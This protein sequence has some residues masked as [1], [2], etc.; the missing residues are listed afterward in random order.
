MRHEFVWPEGIEKTPERQALLEAIKRGEQIIFLSG[1]AGSGKSKLLECVRANT[2][3]LNVA[4][5]APTGLAALNISGM[6]IHRSFKLPIGTLTDKIVRALRPPSMLAHIDLIV[7]DEVS[8]VRADVVAAMDVMLRRA[9]RINEPFGGTQMLFCGDL[10]QLAPVLT[11]EDRAAYIKILSIRGLF[12]HHAKVFDC[13]KPKVLE[14]TKIWRQKD[15]NFIRSLNN[16]RIGK[17][18]SSDLALLNSRR[19]NRPPETHV[20]LAPHNATVDH[21]NAALLSRLPGPQGNIGAEITGA[22]CNKSDRM[23]AD[24]PLSLKEGARVLM[25]NNDPDQRWCNGT[26]ATVLSWTE[27]A[28]KVELDNGERHEVLRARWSEGRYE[29]D[30]L[31]E[32]EAAQLVYVETGSFTQFPM[33]LGWAITIHKSQGMTL[34]RAYIDLGCGIFAHG[35]LYVALSRVVS[36]EGLALSRPIDPSDIIVEPNAMRLRGWGLLA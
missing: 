12:F 24:S 32:T 8:M 1:R 5:L 9:K 22:F 31:T 6:T 15:E 13:A 16:I 10:G 3:F 29:V 18:R 2:D 20:I 21:H 14:L 23:P 30:E 7:I 25:T 4:F 11:R 35:Q 27:H 28:V 26:R 33:R 34:D 19:V 17:T 36:L